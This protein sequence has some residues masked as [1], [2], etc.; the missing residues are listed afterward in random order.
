MFVV[1]RSIIRNLRP[2]LSR[3]KASL[4]AV[5]PSASE[6]LLPPANASE[7]AEELTPAER[8]KRRKYKIATKRPNISLENPREWNRPL[9]PNVV[10]AYDLALKLLAK[11]NEGLKVEVEDL[12]KEIEGKEARYQ[13]SKNVQ[14]SAEHV[15]ELD[16]ELE[17]LREKLHVLEVQSEINLPEVRWKV[18]NAMARMEIPSHRHLVEQ[19]WRKDGD[20]DLLMERIYQMKVVPDLLPELRPSIDL[21]L[22][23]SVLPT[24]VQKV[25]VVE[26][27]A[28]LVPDQTIA[29]P[30]L[31]ANVFHTDTRLYTL[32]LVDPDV[33][34]ESKASYGTYLHWLQPNIPL[35]A[36]QTSQIL[37]I[38]NHTRYIPPHPQQGTPY[39]RYTVLLLPQPPVDGHVFHYNRN[40]E[41]RATPGVPTSQ[42]LDIPVIPDAQRFGFNVRAFCKEWGLSGKRGGGFHLFRQIWDESVSKIYSDILKQ[43]EP[44]YGRLPKPDPYVEVIKYRKKYDS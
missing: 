3:G 25:K 21:R 40:T 43:E 30:R 33:P 12:K 17:R 5:P 44:R 22:A 38:N 6:G 23:A 34:D 14:A 24:H 35:S 15:R 16:E 29:P 31:Y 9:A 28:Y 32:M 20:L 7:E 4:S 36:T 42:H 2:L 18:A 11:D 8:R 39:H 13:E 37:E 41:A 19:K 26:P 27:G 10:P 1:Q